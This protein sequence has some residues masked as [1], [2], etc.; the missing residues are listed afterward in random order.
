MQLHLLRRFTMHLLGWYICF[1]IATF[2]LL[3]V[4][5]NFFEPEMNLGIQKIP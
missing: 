3:T 2:V 1:L 5:M 4:E